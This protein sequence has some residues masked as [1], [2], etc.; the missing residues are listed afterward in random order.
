M[1][2]YPNFEKCLELKNLGFPQK[3]KYQAQYYVLPDT[4]ICIDD[5]SCLKHDGKTD[6]E[7]IFGKLVYKPKL[8]ELFEESPF[9]FEFIRMDDGT[10]MAYSSVPEDPK[11]I[12]ETGRADNAIRVRGA[13]HWESLVLLWIAVKKRKNQLSPPAD[14]AI[15]ENSGNIHKA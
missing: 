11:V 4:L 14:P 12:E 9:L 1:I 10:I 8:E 3:R 15:A 7:D 5:L 6:F 13:T 2:E